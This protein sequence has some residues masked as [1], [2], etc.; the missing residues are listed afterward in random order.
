M[1]AL[2]L[3]FPQETIFSP[4]GEELLK[5][6]AWRVN[7]YKQDI[8]QGKKSTSWK[9]CLK[10]GGRRRRVAACSYGSEEME[11]HPLQGWG[12]TKTGLWHS[13]GDSWDRTQG[14]Q[15]DDAG[16]GSAGL[17]QQMPEWVTVPGNWHVAGHTPWVA[18]LQTVMRQGFLS[19]P[20]DCA[21]AVFPGGCPRQGTDLCQCRGTRSISMSPLQGLQHGK[22]HSGK[23]H[24]LPFLICLPLFSD[25][26][27][28]HSHRQP[29]PAQPQVLPELCALLHSHL[30]ILGAEA[31]PCMQPQRNSLSSAPLSLS[32]QEPPRLKCPV[33]PGG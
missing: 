6:K 22:K 18:E 2:S 28:E 17:F 8:P 21:Q 9:Q 1:A 29:L 20:P 3:D 12:H 4:R 24:S 26:P 30:P 32:L 33:L 13:A 23:S 25:C 10:L 15:P 5:P 31:G 27:G 19:L 14:Q 7:E 16:K 11:L